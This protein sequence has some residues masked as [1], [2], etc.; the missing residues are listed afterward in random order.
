[1][2]ETVRLSPDIRVTGLVEENVPMGHLVVDVPASQLATE[3]IVL[4]VLIGL[5]C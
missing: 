2:K 5:V 1:M 3:L 4:I